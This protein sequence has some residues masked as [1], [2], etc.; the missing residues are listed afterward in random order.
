[1]E[2][3]ILTEAEKDLAKKVA[4]LSGS[5]IRMIPGDEAKKKEILE[6][7]AEE[8]K[9]VAAAATEPSERPL[10]DVSDNLTNTLHAIHAVLPEYEKPSQQR[11][12]ARFAASVGIIEGLLNMIGL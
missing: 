1:M 7:V 8:S 12:K 2:N 4:L 5:L 3:K 6:L 11:A 9:L 10:K